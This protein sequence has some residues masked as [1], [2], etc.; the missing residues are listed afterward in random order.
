M[1]FGEIDIDHSM[2]I[3][4]NEKVVSVEDVKKIVYDTL[5]IVKRDYFE[6]EIRK[7]FYDKE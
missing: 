5:E 1:I 3:K 2:E 6:S 7:W 4:K